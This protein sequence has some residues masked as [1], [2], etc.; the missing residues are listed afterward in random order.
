MSK[1]LEEY[2]L[3]TGG[4]DGSDYQW[5]VLAEKY[6]A[7]NVVYSFDKL[8]VRYGNV[9]KLSYRELMQGFDDVITANQSLR[10]AFPS[11]NYYTNRLL[12]RDWFTINEAESVYAV[13]NLESNGTCVVGGTGWGVQMAINQCKP[14]FLITYSKPQWYEF[15]YSEMMFMEI[16]EIPILTKEFAGIGTRSLTISNRM[17]SNKIIK[18]LEEVFI[19]TMNVINNEM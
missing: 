19:K 17:Y 15:D 8:R 12:L 16:D 1:M 6:K 13:G 3:H 4:A 5:F 11:K 9:L 14:V 7:K 2:T 10:R 18:M